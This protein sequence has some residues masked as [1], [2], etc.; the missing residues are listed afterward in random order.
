MPGDPFALPHATQL[1]GQTTAY[2]GFAPASPVSAATGHSAA[3]PGFA[4]APAGEPGA[5]PAVFARHAAPLPFA[6]APGIEVPVFTTALP[7]ETYARLPAN[8]GTERAPLFAYLSALQPVAIAAA[9]APASAHTSQPDAATGSAAPAGAG[10]ADSAA[11][12]ASAASGF[13]TTGPGSATPHN[14]VYLPQ[15][16]AT[17]PEGALT[18]GDEHTIDLLGKI[19]E[20]VY[21]DPSIPG[22]IRDLINFLQIPVLK[23]A[24]LDKNFFF[25]D[26][27]PARR[28]IELLSRLGWEQRKAPDDPVFQA[29]RRSVDRVGRDFDAEMEV[30]NDAVAELEAAIQSHEQAAEQAL[31]EPIALAMRQE[32]RAIAVKSAQDAVR[33]RVGAGE[34]VAV[35][36]AFLQ[37]KWTSVMTLA[38]T[39]EDDKPGAVN[40]ATKTMDDLIWSVKPKATHEQRKELISR[41]PGLIQRLNKWLDVIKWQDAERLQFFAE[42]A[43]CHASIVRAPIELSPDRQLELAVEAAQQDALRRIEQEKAAEEAAARAEAELDDVELTVDSL[44]RGMWVEFQQEDGTQRKVKL[45]WVSPRR[46]LF[47]F[48]TGA[49]QE[50][51]SMPAD[52]LVEALRDGKAILIGLEG[53]VTRALSEA[54]G[55][56]ANDPEHTAAA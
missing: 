12:P 26:A 42:L 10:P 46:T 18:R 48:S 6:V 35:V 9:A 43:E 39:I 17:M 21:R 20:T 11:G 56:P 45:A 13:A 38:Y 19:F 2:P 47:I 30:F 29:M 5:Y 7:P 40:N 53:V 25:Q 14:V 33:V 44:E 24:L 52:K 3:Y 32:K 4:A 55:A 49:R 23:A 1:A 54:I 27:H 22:E 37:N 34:V 16:K 31:A 8:V 51:F 50:A 36:Q 15:L 28:L 41:L